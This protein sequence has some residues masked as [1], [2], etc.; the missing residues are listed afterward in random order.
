MSQ[1]LTSAAL[2]LTSANSQAGGKEEHPEEITGL[3]LKA[4]LVLQQIHGGVTGRGFRL[5]V[6]NGLGMQ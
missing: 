2:L 3:E 1:A 4:K 6:W 5:N